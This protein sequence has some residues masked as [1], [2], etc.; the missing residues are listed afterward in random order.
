MKKPSLLQRLNGLG[1]HWR[2][3]RRAVRRW[4]QRGADRA[5]PALRTAW[6]FL[7][8][9][10]VVGL[11]AVGTTAIAAAM[12]RGGAPA[13]LRGFVGL[14]GAQ[15]PPAM[16]VPAVAGFLGMCVRLAGVVA[17]AAGAASVAAFLRNRLSL[18][19]LKGAAAGYALLSSL[20]L[21][22]TWRVPS[23]LY[24]ADPVLFDK[25]VRNEMWVKGTARA[26]GPAALAL[27]F[28]FVL[29]LRAVTDIYAGRATT[30][31]AL[32]DRI[33]RSLV[34][35]GHDPRYRK[36]L[37]KAFAIHLFAF[38]VLPYIL[39]WH[40][41]MRPYGIPKGSGSPVLEMVRIRK[42]KKKIEKKYVF[43]LD[44]AISFYVP[45]IDD[46][47]VFEEVEELTERLH[48]AE[49]IGKLGAGGGK[50]GGWPN[51]MD[52]AKVRFIRLE[53]DGGDW[54]QDMGFGADYNMLLVF[55]ELTGFNIWP[56]TEHIHVA[57]LKRFPRK[58]APPFVYLTGG[59]RGTMHLTQ[60]E[61]KTLRHYCLEM[62][63]MV[64]A[65]NGGGNFDQSF[66]ALLQR[67]FPDLRLV[68]ISHDDVIFQQPFA[69]PNGA[70]PLWHHSGRDTMGVKY[71]GR[72]VVF[73]HQGDIN[74]AW[75]EGHSGASKGLAMQAYKVGINVINYAFTQ[76]IQ[77]NFGGTVPR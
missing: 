77:L 59:L 7:T 46:S 49:A 8:W 39:S 11:L 56:R 75:K 73:Y 13:L 4:T 52:K 19:I 36:A 14:T 67:V 28:M 51:G 42:I 25:Y 26:L 70:P 34:T 15:V 12:Y 72:W 44:S 54:D 40:G 41:C 64:F 65:D 50:E 63:G 20:L 33:W 5:R 48:E 24:A 29:V 57:Q 55:R 68:S 60:A 32:G 27:I 9:P 61:I 66:R 10:A 30:T 43:N 3:W 31:P 38:L 76:Y 6:G 69:F 1:P 53:Y 17:L 18:W 74:D 37:Y 22:A 21:L 35:H 16:Q 23:A 2:R 47:E 71:R 45:K 58:R 62:G